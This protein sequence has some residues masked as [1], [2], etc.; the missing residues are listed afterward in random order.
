MTSIVGSAPSLHSEPST[1]RR[2]R[3]EKNGNDST[4]RVIGNSA[5]LAATARPADP[6]STEPSELQRIRAAKWLPPLADNARVPT[7]PH[8]LVAKK[9]KGNNTKD[10]IFDAPRAKEESLG[11][12]MKQTRLPNIN[13]SKARFPKKELQK[14]HQMKTHLRNNT[15]QR[16]LIALREQAVKIDEKAAKRAAEIEKAHQNEGIMWDLLRPLSREPMFEKYIQTLQE[17][18]MQLNYAPETVE[19]SETSSAASS[20]PQS[21]LRSKISTYRNTSVLPKSVTP[22]NAL[23]RSARPLPSLDA[24]LA[25]LKKKSVGSKSLD[26]LILSIEGSVFRPKRKGARAIRGNEEDVPEDAIYQFGKPAVLKVGQA[27]EYAETF[28]AMQAI[29]RE[30][31]QSM[32]ESERDKRSFSNIRDSRHWKSKGSVKPQTEI[33]RD[34]GNGFS[35]PPT[36]KEY[37]KASEVFFNVGDI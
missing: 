19:C 35:K 23:T 3:G 30:V 25:L 26:N 16:F 13:L 6:T 12:L 37:R 21:P 28:K 24:Q 9:L 5:K 8:F 4:R 36:A 29:G 22:L 17:F 1:L 31:G 7:P 15:N 34:R 32:L 18:G 33:S 2:T 27:E 10:G 11:R 14:C 20:A